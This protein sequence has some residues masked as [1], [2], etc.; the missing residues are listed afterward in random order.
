M[1]RSRRKEQLWC[2]RHS[3]EDSLP[4]GKVLSPKNG[5]LKTI[6]LPDILRLGRNLRT[7]QQ[8]TDCL[9]YMKGMALIHPCV[10]ALLVKRCIAY[11]KTRHCVI[12]LTVMKWKRRL[13]SDMVH[14]VLH[15][16]A[17]VHSDD[18]GYWRAQPP[19]PH[20]REGVG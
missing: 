9:I 12:N 1:S 6:L 18:D 2:V 10:Y 3:E 13:H 15:T 5:H 11:I 8:A 19:Q 7:W 14:T 16:G 20:P 17:Y 4:T